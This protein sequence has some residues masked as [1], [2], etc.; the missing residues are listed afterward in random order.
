MTAA[1][2]KPLG[3]AALWVTAI[4][5]ALGTFMQVLDSAIANVSLPTIAGNL[6]ASTDDATWVITAFA[7]AN[8]VTVPLTGWL[9]GRFGVVRTFIASVALFTIT[10]FLCGV[11]TSLP[12]LVFFRLLQGGFSGPMIPGSQALLIA[13]FPAGKRATALGIWSVTALVGPIAGPVLGG[14]ISDNYYWGLIFL[15]NVPVGLFSGF[16]AW[17]ALSSHDT[18]TERL[19]I[20]TVGVILLATWVGALQV[21]LDLGKNDD[22]F[23]SK[24][25]VFLSVIA[26]IAFATWLIWELT[27]A[28]PAVDLS[29]L[30]NRNFFLG[31]AAFCL[32]YALFFATNLILP[33]W[34]QQQLAYTATWAGLVSAPSGV[35][36]VVLTPFL[37]RF[38][39]KRDARWLATLSFA[40]FGISY[41]MR[42]GYT[43][44]S[45][46]THFMLPLLVQGVAMSAFFMAMLTIS[47]EGVA[48]ERVPSATGISNF[49]RITGASFAASIFT[50]AWDR[51]ESLHQ[52]RLS[53]VS[54]PFS[55]VFE[56]GTR[57][58]RGM[59]S[60]HQAAGVVTQQMVGQAYLLSS[61]ELFWICGW[62]SF[63]MIGLV[64]L[65]R[66]PAAHNGPIAAD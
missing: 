7:A 66:R 44:Y 22:W 56:L 2:T 17:R 5:L 20:D 51:R 63:A 27:D 32:G 46:F 59:L 47:L 9:M 12:M 6:G 18:P 34:L 64:W 48:P 25:I 65:A 31:T 16:V 60:D 23:N 52:S 50:T 1:G 36:A 8:G 53:D 21:V 45:D 3:G 24:I 35:V 33:V 61:I 15:I 41:F 19:P 42:A 4:A 26:A 38:G 58:L 29:L 28:H 39:A 40:A 14:Y 10:S 30:R 13:I 37:A 62:L 57:G 11:A 49:A 54:S 43:T 55:Q